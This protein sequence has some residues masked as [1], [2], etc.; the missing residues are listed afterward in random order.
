MNVRLNELQMTMNVIKSDDRL[1]L[2]SSTQE[3][4][5]HSCVEYCIEKRQSF[6]YKELLIVAISLAIVVYAIAKCP[7]LLCLETLFTVLVACALVLRISFK[8]HSES[9]LITAPIGLQLTTTY[10]TGGQKV[11]SL[12]WQSIADVF[13]VDVIHTQKVL[14]YLAIKTPGNGLVTLFQKSAPRLH[15][16][17]IIYKDIYRLL[18]NNR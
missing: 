18:E 14:Y 4:L 12:P 7:T 16:L 6:S 15:F 17:E 9:L 2:K 10:V 5:K 1:V 11:F 13:I 3:S 8:V